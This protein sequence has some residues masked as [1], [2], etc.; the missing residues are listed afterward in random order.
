MTHKRVRI[1]IL[2]SNSTRAGFGAEGR[3]RKAVPVEGTSALNRPPTQKLFTK[4]SFQFIKAAG[5]GVSLTLPRSSSST[6][7]S[8][9][10]FSLSTSNQR[11]E[12]ALRPRLII[13]FV[14]TLPGPGIGRNGNLES[15]AF[16]LLSHLFS[17]QCQLQN[18]VWGRDMG[19]REL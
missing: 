13:H 8:A 2:Y 18:H 5:E 6:P 14:T 11:K 12:E 3:G 19:R 17:R 16:A 4:N 9:T 15:V 10:T 7:T 1:I